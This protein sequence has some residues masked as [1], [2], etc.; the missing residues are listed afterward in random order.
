MKACRRRACLEGRRPW[1][2]S[3]STRPK[4]VFS[5][6]EVARFD[7]EFTGFGPNRCEPGSRRAPRTGPS[8][9]RRARGEVD[10]QRSKRD[11]DRSKQ[12]GRAAGG[13]HRRRNG[14]APQR[15][16]RALRDGERSRATFPLPPLRSTQCA[17][18]ALNAGHAHPWGRGVVVAAGT[19]GWEPACAMGGIPDG[20]PARH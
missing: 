17:G 4:S 5:P 12:M 16:R 3:A 15:R 18:A 10:K 8:G 2:A 6:A 13:W 9:C 19:L 11:S 20:K 1:R 14:T 7:V